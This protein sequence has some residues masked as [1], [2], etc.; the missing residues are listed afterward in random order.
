MKPKH[1]RL[2]LLSSVLVGLGLSIGLMLV[3]LQ[4]SV[5]FFY[6]PSDLLH[7]TISP[8]ERLR[9]GGLVEKSSLHQKRGTAHFK[10]TDQEE[11]GVVAEGYL[12]TP[13]HF[14]ATTVLAKHDETYM[15][16]EVAD[17]LKQTGLWR[18]AR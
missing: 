7:K 11:Q 1:Q 13:T 17:R 15:P 12:I 8:Q 4:E 14:Q 6:T 18:D 2:V 3:A 16:K 10:I 9:I 5:V